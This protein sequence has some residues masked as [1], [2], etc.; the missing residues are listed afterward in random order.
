[1]PFF[2]LEFKNLFLCIKDNTVV[3]KQ[4]EASKNGLL[5]LSIVCN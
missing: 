5:L 2:S 1:M 3:Q 4:L